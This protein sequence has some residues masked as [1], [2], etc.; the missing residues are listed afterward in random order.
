MQDFDREEIS[1]RTDDSEYVNFFPPHYRIGRTK[2][3][4]VT[5]GV[6]SGVGKG[7]FT[8]SLSHLLQFLGFSVSTM[9]IDGYLNLDAGTLNPY[10]HGETFVL[11]DGTE[12]DLDL[13]TYERFLDT[14][15]NSFNYMTS[16]K[17]YWRILAKER[18][19]EYLGRDVQIVPH[20]TGEIKYLIREKAKEAPYDIVLVEIGGTV[21]DIENL[22]F[23]E[24]A[25]ELMMDE[26][27]GNIMFAHVTMVPWSEASGEQ[28]SK[29]T[30]HSVKKLLEMG[31]Q[32][33]LV[34]CRSKEALQLKVREKIS[35]YC[36]V[37]IEQVISSPDTESIYT[38]PAIF[39]KQRLAEIATS[40]LQL[41][42]P[43][44]DKDGFAVPFE[45]FVRH[46]RRHCDTLTVAI[47][48]KYSTM[49]DSY[50]S[51]TNALE[52]TAPGENV[53]IDVRFIDTTEFDHSA[54]ALHKHLDG[55]HGI[56]VPGGYGLRGTEGMIRF[57]QYAREN[58]IP[59]LG[60]CFGF[61]LAAVEFARHVCGLEKASSTEF[62]QHT[63]EPL[64]SL[65]PEQEQIHDLGGT[66]RL[67]G[68]D[69]LLVP[70]T[71]VQRIYSKDTIRERFRHRYEFNNAYKAALEETGLVFSGM[72]PDRQIMQIFEYPAHPFFIA[73]QFHPELLSRPLRPHPLFLAFVQAA[74]AHQGLS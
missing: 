56:I 14:T 38:L 50:I 39:Q 60:L 12:C 20:V 15:L 8:A 73:T 33:D 3:V 29:P 59:Y 5:G 16:G 11:D 71:Q 26:G 21:G 1:L 53:H 65:L 68:R 74:K 46:A 9:K 10:R 27:R 4:I 25:R 36:N 66:Q 47:T 45:P 49:R 62:E 30:Q 44:P 67:G 55:V 34:V 57:I 40:R 35:L 70:R 6:M 64:I 22:H 2:Y 31:I 19:G 32:P 43:Y 23:I 17:I 51:I 13:G 54:Q 24:A 42:M 48:G 52:H 41:N 7:V 58:R 37:P 69:V 28:K 61:Q 72:T 18:R 63:P